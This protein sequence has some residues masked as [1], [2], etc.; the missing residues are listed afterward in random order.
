MKYLKLVLVIASIIGSISCGDDK[1]AQSQISFTDEAG[2]TSED[3][4]PKNLDLD[5][6]EIDQSPDTSDGENLNE[7]PPTKE[8]LDEESSNETNSD[9]TTPES[10]ELT[11]IYEEIPDK[12]VPGYAFSIRGSGFEAFSLV[13]IWIFSEP[14]LLEV[15]EA[16]IN[17]RING[18]VTIPSDF[19][20]GNHSLEM[21]GTDLNGESTTVSSPV[22]VGVDD[23]SPIIG[24][25][26]VSATS[27][28]ITNGPQSFTVSV[29]ASDDM[30]GVS[31]IC[32]NWNG[33]QNEIS[34]GTSG[35]QGGV[36]TPYSGM[37]RVSGTDT[38]GVWQATVTIPAGL[39]SEVF[40]FFNIIVSDAVGNE[41]S[42]YEWLAP[43]ITITNNATDDSPPT[44]GTISVS[45]T[46]LDITNGP[47]SFTVS[48]EA[49]DDMTGV[50]YICMNWN[51][52]QNE[53]S[54]GTSG[55]QGGVGTPYSGMTR[56]S[57]TDTNGVWQATVT[58]PAGLPSE[59]FE[60]F[61]I[62]VSDAVGN[63]YSS[64]APLTQDIIITN[65]TG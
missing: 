57:G 54:A 64:Y 21:N 31:Y 32:M 51:G 29:E 48:V 27:L 58:I 14:L 49:S 37:T 56:V 1:E 42:S 45:A 12:L 26:S 24:T 10:N 13:E 44:I 52:P 46:S 40:E 9:I 61:N 47:Q 18:Q 25:I 43:H 53:I 63:E 19:P 60:F 33:P 8:N 5:N 62:I 22:I 20:L 17:G 39:P 23:S 38:N 16:D 6:S 3:S 59:V 28:D 7:E 34:A 35:C 65:G 50:S 11:P 55:C 36:G 4:G 30:T 41:Y 15:F 2:K